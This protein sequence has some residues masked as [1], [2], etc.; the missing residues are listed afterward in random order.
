MAKFLVSNTQQAQQEHNDNFPSPVKNTVRYIYVLAS[1]LFS[2]YT[3]RLHNE[4]DLSTHLEKLKRHN[5]DNYEKKE[6][7][8]CASN[9][10]KY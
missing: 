3:F 6:A 4:N 2:L 9:L 8:S 1:E 5:C 7:C 10:G